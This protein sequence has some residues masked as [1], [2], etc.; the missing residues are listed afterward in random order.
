LVNWELIG[1]GIHREEQGLGVVNL[2][3]VQQNGGIHAPT[4]RYHDGLFYI[5]VTNVY[6]PKEKG[7]PGVM[8]NFIIREN[9]G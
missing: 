5:I 4:I 2:W 8:V 9:L 6:S 7:K 1:Y 3:D